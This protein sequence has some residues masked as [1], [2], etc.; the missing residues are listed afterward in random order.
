MA[1]PQGAILEFPIQSNFPKPV[2]TRGIRK[3]MK[4]P[5]LDPNLF[6]GTSMPDKYKPSGLG[7]TNSY[8]QPPS[9]QEYYQQIEEDDRFSVASSDSSLSS[10]SVKK[11]NIAKKG[12]KN[13][14]FEL[15]IK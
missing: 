2:E 4:G 5:S 10:V 11:V 12:S 13:Q 15:N 14:G 7:T 3:E 9:P 6:S 1:N 8:P